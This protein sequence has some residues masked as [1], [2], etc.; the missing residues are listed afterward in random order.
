MISSQLAEAVFDWRYDH[1]AHEVVTAD[2]PPAQ[3]FAG[4]RH[5]ASMVAAAR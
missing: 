5:C 3:F 4:V 1:E 2:R